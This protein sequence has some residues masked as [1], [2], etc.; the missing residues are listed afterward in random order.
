MG[1]KVKNKTTYWVL[2]CA[3]YCFP[4][5]IMF[6][7]AV[8]PDLCIVSFITVVF[9]RWGCSGTKRW[10]TVSPLYT[11]LQGA[12]F[13]RCERVSYRMPGV[14]EIAACLHLLLQLA[15][16]LHHLPSP[17]SNSS[18][19]F[20]LCQFWNASYCTVPLYFSRYCIV[21]L[22]MF[23]SFLCFLKCIIHGRSTINLSQHS[24][25]LPVVL[26]VYRN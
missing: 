26:A 23:S 13:Q 8:Y 19:L 1:I 4:C 24:A 16:Q 21:G 7:L 14:S 3:R 10:N 15:L 9:C 22:K 18:C 25:I 20:T 11:N 12:N 5:L 17:V 2:R 6:Y